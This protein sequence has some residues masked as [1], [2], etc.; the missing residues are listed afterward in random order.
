MSLNRRQWLRQGA[1]GAFALLAGCGPRAGGPTPLRTAERSLVWRHSTPLPIV[2][3][4]LGASNLGTVLRQR[5][6]AARGLSTGDLH[7]IDRLMRE[8]LK[9]S[10]GVGLAAPQV[11]LGRRVVLVQLQTKQRPVLF[12]VDPRIVRQAAKRVDGYEAC[13]SIRDVGG[14]VSRAEWVEVSYY[15]LAGRRRQHRAQGWEARIFQHELDHLDGRLYVDLVAGALLPMDEV[16][17]RRRLRKRSAVDRPAVVA[18]RPVLGDV[19]L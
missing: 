2:Q 12:C 19:I 7:R 8:T 6:L 16:R 18:G 11:G 14:L 4:R 3:Y 13:L 10:G 15:D 5:A 9:R 1:G 17:R